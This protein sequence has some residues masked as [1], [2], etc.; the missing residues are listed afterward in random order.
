MLRYVL[1]GLAAGT[2]VYVACVEMLSSEL[3][4]Q[5]GHSHDHGEQGLAVYSF[6]KYMSIGMIITVQQVHLQKR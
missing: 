5:H 6:I 3:G 1:E 4:H 2:F